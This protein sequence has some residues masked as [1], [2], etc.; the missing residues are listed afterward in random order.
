MSK[1]LS[2]TEKKRRMFQKMYKSLEN[3]MHG[4]NL[5]WWN[6]LSQE[7]RYSLLFRWKSSNKNKL[8][9][10]LHIYKEFYNPIKSRYREAIIDHILNKK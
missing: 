9:H 7:A 4:E 2:N 8:K 6:S 10:F 1:V 3:K 5:I